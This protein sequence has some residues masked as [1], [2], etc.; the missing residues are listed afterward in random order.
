MALELLRKSST[1]A[2][3]SCAVSLIL[4]PSTTSILQPAGLLSAD[5]RCKALDSSADGWGMSEA[6]VAFGLSIAEAVGTPGCCVILKGGFV[7]SS[8]QYTNFLMADGQAQKNVIADALTAS[9]LAASDI[10]GLELHSAGRL[11]LRLL[12]YM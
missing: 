1:A 8:S 7:H 10:T 3:L 12:S 4:S 11:F 9:N 6:C 5:G 2:A